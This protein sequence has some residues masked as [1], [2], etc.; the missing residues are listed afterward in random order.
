MSLIP[1][2]FY[3]LCDVP[4]LRLDVSVIKVFGGAMTDIMSR[5]V[6]TKTVMSVSVGARLHAK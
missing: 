2:A 1:W 6:L 5:S 3:L 4:E